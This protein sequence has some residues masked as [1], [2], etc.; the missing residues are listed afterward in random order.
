[1][2]RPVLYEHYGIDEYPL[3]ANAVVAV[4]SYTVCRMPCDQNSIRPK[5]Y[6]MHNCLPELIFF[7]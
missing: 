1:M 5:T 7:F 3:G 6:R 2:V 4:I